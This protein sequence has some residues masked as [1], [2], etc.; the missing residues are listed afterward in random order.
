MT[1][2]T[3]KQIHLNL[4]GDQVDDFDLVQQS[5]GIA[6]YNNTLRYLIRQAAN[7]I[8]TNQERKQQQVAREN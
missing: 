8:R 1:Q 2:Q 3:R 6:D 5:L 4:Y 7:E